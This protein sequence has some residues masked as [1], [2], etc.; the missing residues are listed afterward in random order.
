MITKCQFCDY[1]KDTPL[2]L[3]ILEVASDPELPEEDKM[4]WIK[5]LAE[6]SG[7]VD[8]NGVK[9]HMGKMHKD[10]TYFGIWPI[11]I[12]SEEEVN[13]IERDSSC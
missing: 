8:W 3:I 13:L 1:Y 11:T 10:K 7:T 4:L 2:S 5:R 9:I 6:S 12:W